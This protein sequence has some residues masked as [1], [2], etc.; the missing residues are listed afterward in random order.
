MHR[1][2]SHEKFISSAREY[3]KKE[4]PIF[5]NSVFVAPVHKDHVRKFLDES[6]RNQVN[7]GGW[8]HWRKVFGRIEAAMSSN[9]ANE[10]IVDQE[11]QEKRGKNVPARTMTRK[12]NEPVPLATRSPWRLFDP[13]TESRQLTNDELIQKTMLLAIGADE[14]ITKKLLDVYIQ[15][16]QKT[17][18]DITEL[19]NIQMQLEQIEAGKKAARAAVSKWD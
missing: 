3:V 18:P 15:L 4:A 17:D 1:R 11:L 5:L 7:E 19:R 6:K 12:K 10:V 13:P 8:I 2:Q 9:R 14:R 16:N